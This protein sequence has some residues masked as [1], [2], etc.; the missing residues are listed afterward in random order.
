MHE[1]KPRKTAVTIE[2][3][4]DDGYAYDAYISREYWNGY[5]IPFFTL[6]QCERIVSDLRMFDT[7][8]E[9][10]IEGTAVYMREIGDGNEWERLEEAESPENP[11]ERLYALGGGSWMWQRQDNE[12]HTY[13]VVYGIY[14]DCSITGTEEHEIECFADEIDDEAQALADII[15]SMNE[16]K[17][18][19]HDYWA[20]VE[21]IIEE[22]GSEE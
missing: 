4:R 3:M 2:S 11:K 6:A 5:L 16:C 19:G 15:E 13:L 1:L 17:H 21:E 18:R 12:M 10:R 9:L 22:V 8:Y 7:F 14:V 20:S